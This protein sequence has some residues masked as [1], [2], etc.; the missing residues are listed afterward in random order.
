M[1]RFTLSPILRYCGWIT[2]FV[3]LVPRVSVASIPAPSVDYCRSS[4]ALQE[5]SIFYRAQVPHSPPGTPLDL[6]I[7]REQQSVERLRD[8]AR[9]AFRTQPPEAFSWAMDNYT[10]LI[11]NSERDSYGLGDLVAMTQISEALRYRALLWRR[12][13][14]RFST[15]KE[16]PSDNPYELRFQVTLDLSYYCRYRR[17]TQDL[18][19]H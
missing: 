13:S 15:V 12:Y 8:E 16:A 18:V 4:Q 6:A 10:F 19:T 9:A 17:R 7:L 2:L 5:V 14:E 1:S 11:P 3:A